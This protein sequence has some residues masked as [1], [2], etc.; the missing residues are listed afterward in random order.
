MVSV[1]LIRLARLFKVQAL[2]AALL[3][4]CLCP[5]EVRATHIVGG[6]MTY[7]CLGNNQYEIRLVVFRDCYNG[8]PYFDT[9]VA[10]VG[11]YQQDVLVDSLYMP[12]R[13]VDDTLSPDLNDSCLVVPPNVCVH[14]TY[15][16]DTITLPPAPGGYTIVYQRCCRNYTISNIIDPDDTG[17]TYSIHITEEAMA[18]CNNSPRFT[19]WPP[20]YICA[21]K[22]LLFDHSAIDEDGDSIVYRLCAP[23]DG[24]TDFDPRPYPSDQTIPKPVV[25][26]DPYSL[27]N[28]MGG[29]PLTID[30]LTGLMDAVPNTIGQF[31]VGVCMDEYRDGQLLSVTRRDF[32]Y[33]VGICGE[34]VAAFFVPD[35]ACGMELTVEDQS[36]N[37]DSWLWYFDGIGN[38]QAASSDFEPTYTYPDSGNY[39]VA[40]II[41][42]GSVCTDTFTQNVQIWPQT[43]N[44]NFFIPPL[45]SCADSI[46]LFA[47]NTSWDSQVGITSYL[48]E[49]NI[50]PFELIAT[51]TTTDYAYLFTDFE[52]TILL[53]LIAVN[54]RGCRDSLL[55]IARIDAFTDLPEADT[56]DACAG[57]Q[58]QLNPG[59]NPQYLYDWSPKGLLSNDQVANPTLQA[60]ENPGVYPFSVSISRLDTTFIG[61]TVS[62][63]DT[64]TITRQVFLRVGVPYPVNLPDTLLSCLDT[65]LTLIATSPVAASFIWSDGPA[66]SD[67][68]GSGNQYTV[69]LTAGQER[70]LY[71]RVDHG[72]GCQSVASALAVNGSIALNIPDLSGC[73]GDTVAL[74]GQVTPAGYSLLLNWSVS[75]DI[76][77]SQLAFGLVLAPGGPENVG[78]DLTNEW[79]CSASDTAALTFGPAFPVVGDEDTIVCSDVPVELMA[80][81]PVS[82]GF[83][84]YIGSV[85]GVPE[86]NGPLFSASVSAGEEVMYFVEVDHGNGCVSVDSVLVTNAGFLLDA[87]PEVIVC[88]G[89]TILLE[90]QALPMQDMLDWMWDPAPGAIGPMDESELLVL[91]E[92]DAEYVVSAQNQFGCEAMTSVEVE[93]AGNAQAVQISASP[94]TLFVGESTQLL[95]Q[96]NGVGASY[97]WTPSFSLNFP[98]IPNPV[99][100]P[101]Q[102]TTYTVT[103]T[104]P[105]GCVAVRTI[106]VVV[107][108]APCEAPYVFF[109]NVF[110]PNGDGQNDVLR[111]YGNIL[112]EVYF[113]VYNRWGELVFEGFSE[114]DTWDGTWKG[115]ALSADVFGYI[116]RVRCI[117][118]REY[119]RKGNVTLLR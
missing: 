41:N 35:T 108:E 69:G 23:F 90:A 89:D 107:L 87:G 32:Q 79:G 27:D 94:D 74:T 15:Y 85:G 88:Q 102:T 95:A 6:E 19:N 106:T 65:S 86:G 26:K 118:G 42:P 73:I 105:E 92:Q 115:E 7:R 48:W 45:P 39:E 98:D 29:V 81:S 3:M 47:K 22:P 109:P 72:N 113:A 67:I 66:F 61:G 4:C 55:R 10:Y 93:V 111:V 71:V 78:L 16:L 99:A 43:L 82:E 13:M 14:T 57:D 50:F 11:V 101:D 110:S 62:Q 103:V 76:V 18:V 96:T 52:E 54:E 70:L 80:E 63:I 44:A 25:W 21:D 49:L 2:L 59:G 9:S 84:W 20:V 36:Q 53:K 40:L 60:P 75:Q 37:A 119:T 64:C 8:V 91:A 117:G 116:L 83:S 51:D 100:T 12:F 28:V 24:A 38:T 17:A 46:E 33:N 68:L 1:Q 104:T 31:V 34:P 5:Q 97:I 30:S 58:V 114:D 112:E 77:V 56:L